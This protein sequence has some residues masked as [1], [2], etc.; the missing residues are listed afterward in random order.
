MRSNVCVVAD[1]LLWYFL[2]TVA[3]TLRLITSWYGAS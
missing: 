1:E 2:E 3:S